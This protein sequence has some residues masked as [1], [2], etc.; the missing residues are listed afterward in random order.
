MTELG[1]MHSLC[2][3]LLESSS[4]SLPV[5]SLKNKKTKKQKTGLAH[6]DVSM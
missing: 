5:C 2:L 4:G 3:L 1:A 6:I